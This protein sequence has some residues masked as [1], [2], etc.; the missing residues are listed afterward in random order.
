MSG[1]Y[2]GLCSVVAGGT[3]VQLIVYFL[4]GTNYKQVLT[5]LPY[6][7]TYTP[8]IFRTIVLFILPSFTSVG[9]FAV[10]TLYF[11]DNVYGF[12]TRCRKCGYIL[13]GIKEPI[14]SECGERI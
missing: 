2:R 7:G 8:A 9:V 1:F 14:C 13:K 11:M 4:A 10:L 12:E 6:V 3:F 5:T